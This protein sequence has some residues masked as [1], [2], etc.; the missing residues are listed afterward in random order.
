[1]ATRASSRWTAPPSSGLHTSL[2]LDA[3]GNPVVSYYRA[4]GGDLKLAHCNDADCAGGDESIVAVDTLG[5]VGFHTSLV[6]DAAGNPVISY[7]SE[8]AGD[9][10]LVHCNDADC[11]G[12]DE[13]I[14]TVDSEGTVGL[15]TSL[16]LDTAGN[17]VIS[18]HDAA[19]ADLKI[20]HCNDADC[21][22][23][24]ESIVTVDSAGTV[25]LDTSLQLDATGNPVIS[26]LDISS[27]D[28]RSAIATTPNC[29]GGDESVVSV[30]RTGV[31]G[32]DT[33]LR[34]GHRPGTR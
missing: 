3:A 6:L 27:D 21:A 2:A 16:Q 34:A 14:V 13:S 17:P 19:K 7:Q 25:G 11:A 8:S 10:K 12:G 9:L 28:L 26:Y 4:V 33:S 5:F 18:Y 22:G 23:G 20:T 1:M 15:D 29:A 32:F 31:V 30:H 24:D